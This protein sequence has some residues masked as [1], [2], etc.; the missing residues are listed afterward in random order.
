MVFAEWH[1]ELEQF[2]EGN[3]A[4]VRHDALEWF[5]KRRALFD[6]YNALRVCDM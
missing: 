1:H 5:P 3:Y 2:V 4:L 6:R